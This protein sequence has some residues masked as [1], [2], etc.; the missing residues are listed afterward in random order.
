MS[1]AVDSDKTLNIQTI[2]N[3]KLFFKECRTLRKKYCILNFYNKNAIQKS[4]F[5]YLIK[6]LS[7]SLAVNSDKILNIQTILNLK[8]FFKEC[9][10]FREN[11]AF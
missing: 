1:L 10:T 8:L 2:L 3:L 9:G 7:M 6:Y 5:K 11:I 4:S